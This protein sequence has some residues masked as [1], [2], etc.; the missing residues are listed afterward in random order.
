[1]R[2]GASDPEAALAHG[3]APGVI[4]GTSWAIAGVVATVAGVLLAAG[5]TGVDLTLTAVTFRAFPAM[6]LGGLDSAE[7]AVAGGLLVG[8][9]EVLTARLRHA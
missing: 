2:A 3:I 8:L 6:I 1:M 9:T 5:P 7:G 4:H